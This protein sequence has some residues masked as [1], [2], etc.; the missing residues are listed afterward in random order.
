MYLLTIAFIFIRSP[1]E[2][3]MSCYRS[4]PVIRQRSYVP[5]CA[6]TAPTICSI[7]TYMLSSYLYCQARHPTWYPWVTST[8]TDGIEVHTGITHTLDY[9][10]KKFFQCATA[11]QLI[12]PKERTNVPPMI[13]K[14]R[15]N[16]KYRQPVSS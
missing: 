6:G 10:R 7:S 4:T 13:I 1:F 3:I 15:G 5:R 12:V 14:Q 2:F 8:T 11:F 16:K 9:H